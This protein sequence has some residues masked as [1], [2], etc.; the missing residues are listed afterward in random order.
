MAPNSHHESVSTLKAKNQLNASRLDFSW[1]SGVQDGCKNRCKI[2][3]KM[4]SKIEY[5]LASIFQ[6]FWW[7]L[8]SKLG[9]MCLQDAPRRPNLAPK[10]AQEPPKRRPRRVKNRPRAAQE[11]TRNLPKRAL[12]PG[13]AQEPPRF[14]PDL[15]FGAYLLDF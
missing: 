3:L 6:R 8:D 14:P 15:D 1:F 9:A 2:D 13:D 4:D 11:A 10:T 12:E 5:N 7:I